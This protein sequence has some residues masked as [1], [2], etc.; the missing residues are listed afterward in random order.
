MAFVPDTVRVGQIWRDNDK[1][2]RGRRL[3][4][5]LVD[6]EAALCAVVLPSGLGRRTTIKLSRFRPNSTGYVLESEPTT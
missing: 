1:R 6:E 2:S 3:Q 4:V 5:L